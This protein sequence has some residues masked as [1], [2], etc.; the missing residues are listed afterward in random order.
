MVVGKATWKYGPAA[1]VAVLASAGAS[2]YGGASFGA[3]LGAVFTPGP[4]AARVRPYLGVRGSVAVPLV[5]DLEM[6]TGLTDALIVPI[7]IEV[8]GFADTSLF[9]EAGYLAFWTQSA[10]NDGSGSGPAR[11][12][13]AFRSGVYLGAGI[14]HIFGRAT[15]KQTRGDRRDR[16]TDDVARRP[17]VAR[18]SLTVGADCGGYY[19]PPRGVHGRLDRYVFSIESSS[20]NAAPLL[21]GGASV[22]ASVSGILDPPSGCGDGTPRKVPLYSRIATAHAEVATVAGGP[23]EITITTGSPGDTELLLTDDAGTVVDATPL[24]VRALDRI[25]IGD[26][27]S[28]LLLA[29]I[30]AHER[31]KLFAGGERAI[32]GGVARVTGGGVLSASAEQR[33]GGTCPNSNLEVWLTGTPGA[34]GWGVAGPGGVNAMRSYTVLAPDAVDAITLAFQG[35]GKPNGDHRVFVYA[36]LLQGGRPVLSGGC[37][38]SAADPSVQV[39]SG[40]FAFATT[41]VTTFFTLAQAGSFPVTCTV[42]GG[43]A[44]AGITLVR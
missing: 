11:L 36:T 30:S 28:T 18:G 25:D 21:A 35:D 17:G 6:S 9:I 31:V 10:A 20:T 26:V 44:S 19:A 33:F 16:L 13:G 39:K 34:G 42:Q 7:G 14:T 8:R 2:W 23:G 3:D 15:P 27:D 41:R 5:R 43:T 32:G 4:R 12:E 37:T 1:W 40:A 22:R 38:W 24:R 29:G